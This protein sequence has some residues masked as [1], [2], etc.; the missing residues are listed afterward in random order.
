MSDNI[1][2]LKHKIDPDQP[3]AHRFEDKKE[4]FFQDEFKEALTS[5][6]KHIDRLDGLEKKKTSLQNPEEPL[7][8]GE[9]E[10]LHRHS[11][12]GIFGPR[13]VGKTSFLLTLKKTFDGESGDGLFSDFDLDL[14]EKIT[15]E[16]KT[17]DTIDPSRIENEDKLLV[18]I[19]STVLDLVR[20]NNDGD[21]QNNRAIQDALEDLSRRFRIL[22]PDA[23]ENVLEETA[24]D[25]LRFAGEVLFDAN[26]GPKL[27]KAFH[28]FLALAAEDLGVKCFL[29]PIDD[30]DTSFDK[31]WPLLETLRK[32]L[33]TDR[34]IT[35]VSG[36][37]EFFDLIVQQ[38]AH[39][40]TET[41]REAEAEYSD[42]EYSENDK[43]VSSGE[44]LRRKYESI[45][46]FPGQYLQKIFPVNNRLRLPDI[47]SVVLDSDT[48]LDVEA[49]QGRYVP[50][51]SSVLLMSRLLFGTP[52][53]PA[54]GK[55]YNEDGELTIFF[56][57]ENSK[58]EVERIQVSNLSNRIDS[59]SID[60]L[61]PPNTRRFISFL[62]DIPEL[63]DQLTTG[64]KSTD[65]AIDLLN[66]IAE[67]HSSLLRSSGMDVGDIDRLAEGGGYSNL[68]RA[69]FTAQVS[70]RDLASL[71][72]DLFRDHSSYDQWRALLSLVGGALYV[73]WSSTLTGP[74]RYMTKVKDTL[75]VA[76]ERDVGLETLGTDLNEPSWKSRCRLLRTI[77]SDMW[78]VSGRVES[79]DT[80]MRVPRKRRN[81][82]KK[83]KTFAKIS[84][85]SSISPDYL[86]WWKEAWERDEGGKPFKAK[87]RAVMPESIFLRHA[88][89]HAHS[90]YGLFRTAFRRGT[91]NFRYIDFRRGL[92]RI[93]DLIREYKS[94]QN[95]KNNKKGRDDIGVTKMI[96]ES[97]D[98]VLRIRGKIKESFST[99]SPDEEVLQKVEDKNKSPSDREG[100]R[101]KEF[102]KVVNRWC[103]L[104]VKISSFREEDMSRG[105]EK[106]KINLIDGASLAPSPWVAV[107][108]Y[109]RFTTNSEEIADLPWRQHTV[110]TMLERHTMAFLNSI[111]QKEVQFRIRSGQIEKEISDYILSRMD[112]GLVRDSRKSI[113][114]INGMSEKGGID[115]SEA[116]MPQNSFTRNVNTIVDLSDELRNYDS[117][118]LK[119]IPYTSFWLCCPF[120][121][122]LMS[123][124]VYTD[125]ISKNKYSDSKEDGIIQAITH[126]VDGDESSRS[127][128]E[129]VFK[130][131]IKKIFDGKSNFRPE[132]QKS[133][134]KFHKDDHYM[135]DIHDILSGIARA[136]RSGYEQ[137]KAKIKEDKNYL[138]ELGLRS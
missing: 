138:S 31:G 77:F 11:T 75:S 71:E 99:P 14:T 124:E 85:D 129:K 59:N 57:P 48:D 55:Q 13:G 83:N 67:N 40:R 50:L 82:Y 86:R 5:I 68:T 39:E 81:S 136:D 122:T 125:I 137:T 120:L 84:P 98:F 121:L 80:A 33:S 23:T 41:Y 66:R 134:F 92:A 131:Y 9:A 56:G 28:R 112:F 128:A 123:R 97:E 72:S 119:I 93:D 46:R 58:E 62:E 4:I 70:S 108:A 1:R 21:L 76:K 102:R 106:W 29:L 7:P 109:D 6:C 96:H 118:L 100:E 51:G 101:L 25:P 30:V 116:E 24:S 32:Y 78:E 54:E 27:A 94:V 127:N 79:F 133:S 65:V 115:W 53:V 38:K 19:T 10:L 73:D 60:A 117:S 110:G 17:L 87:N 18:T 43:R 20:R 90:I 135:F 88:D 37:L 105:S 26:S 3:D 16:V 47:H 44:D 113:V 95:R 12:I 34:L 64:A 114:E 111:L 42:T 15:K 104:A 8:E 49:K 63:L 22:F 61:L 103:S 126:S 45:R 35:V 89:L 69:F 52:Y 107:N 74:I 36:D 132:W 130:A 2:I 91:S